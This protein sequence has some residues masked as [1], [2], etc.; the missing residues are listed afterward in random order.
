LL[1]SSTGCEWPEKNSR[2]KSNPEDPPYRN[3]RP[4]L[5]CTPSQSTPTLWQRTPG[6]WNTKHPL[7]TKTPTRLFGGAGGTFIA[8]K[9]QFKFIFGFCR[10]IRLHVIIKSDSL[11]AATPRRSVFAEL[12]AAYET[13]SQGPWRPMA[14]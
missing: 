12:Q 14:A 11:G 9:L 7:E 3:Q 13:H 10:H 6:A 8:Q 5:P 4:V 1:R 2:E